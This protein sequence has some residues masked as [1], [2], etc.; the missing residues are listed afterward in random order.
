VTLATPPPSRRTIPPIS[1]P[2]PVA[3]PQRGSGW[4]WVIGA[5]WLAAMIPLGREWLSHDGPVAAGTSPVEEGTATVSVRWD[6]TRAVVPES[7]IAEVEG[8]PTI[9][10]AERNLHLLV[11]TPVELGSRRGTEREI[12]SGIAH[13]Q[14]IVADGS[15]AVRRGVASR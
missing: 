10:V 1:L 4:I 9:F 6:G 3:P 2:E 8:K 7:A 12:V 11:A 13:G 5:L 15:S 14:L